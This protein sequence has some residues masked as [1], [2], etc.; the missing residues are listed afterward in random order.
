VMAGFIIIGLIARYFPVFP[1]EAPAVAEP[2]EE[3]LE[4]YVRIGWSV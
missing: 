2:A 1:K 4:G 3:D